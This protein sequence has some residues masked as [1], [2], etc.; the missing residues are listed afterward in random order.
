MVPSCPVF[1]SVINIYI[2]SFWEDYISITSIPAEGMK[3]RNEDIVK[4]NRAQHVPTTHEQF[5]PGINE[6]SYW[7]REE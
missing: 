5:K 3:K 1:S 2:S 7:S 6:D 4:T